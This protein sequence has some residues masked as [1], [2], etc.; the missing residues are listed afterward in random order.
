M[1]PPEGEPQSRRVGGNHPERGPRGLEPVGEAL[2]A[3]DGSRGHCL[4]LPGWYPEPPHRRW[5]D[6]CQGLSYWPSLCLTR[7]APT[8]GFLPTLGHSPVTLFGTSGRLKPLS[9]AHTLSLH[10]LSRVVALKRSVQLLWAAL[11][12]FQPPALLRL[13]FL[14][15]LKIKRSWK[16]SPGTQSGCEKCFPLLGNDFQR[17][18]QSRVSMGTLAVYTGSLGGAGVSFT[19]SGRTLV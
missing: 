7:P 11:G 9:T 13:L 4:L 3:P 8:Q 15:A 14:A 19:A 10:G 6:V 18:L 12:S 1:S 16:P 17:I 5:A 2:A